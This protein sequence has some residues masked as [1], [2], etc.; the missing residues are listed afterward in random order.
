[1]SDKVLAHKTILRGFI[2]NPA[3]EK[4][5]SSVIAEAGKAGIDK[6]CLATFLMVGKSLSSRENDKRSIVSINF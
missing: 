4:T 1:M 2:F 6:I 5:L 3:L